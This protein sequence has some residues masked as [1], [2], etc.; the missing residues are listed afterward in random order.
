MS[1]NNIDVIID[2]LL[3]VPDDKFSNIMQTI[4]E[5]KRDL[6]SDFNPDPDDI[7]VYELNKMIDERCH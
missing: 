3:G 2:S 1:P 4:G 6:E 5:L 7:I